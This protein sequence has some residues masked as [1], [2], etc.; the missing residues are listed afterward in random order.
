[1]RIETEKSQNKVFK[2]HVPNMSLTLHFSIYKLFIL[3]DLFSLFYIYNQ[4]KYVHFYFLWNKI[5]PHFYIHILRSF[6]FFVK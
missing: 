5:V 6:P 4:I 2:P 1:M 3:F